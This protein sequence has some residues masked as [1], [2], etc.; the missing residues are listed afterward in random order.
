MTEHLVL[1]SL[2]FTTSSSSYLLKFGINNTGPRSAGLSY[3]S[4]ILLHLWTQIISAFN[5]RGW[6]A[7]EEVAPKT[8]SQD[9][10]KTEYNF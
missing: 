4:I 6:V 2:L 1:N 8:L 9:E 10:L 7:K 3:R 5:E